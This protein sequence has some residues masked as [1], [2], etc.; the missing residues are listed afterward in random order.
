[1][2]RAVGILAQHDQ[3]ALKVDA[4][5]GLCRGH[6]KLNVVRLGGLGT[7]P[8]GFRMDGNFPVPEELEVKISD[9]FLE[10]DL[11]LFLQGF[12]LREER[13]SHAVGSR[14]GKIEPQ[15][16]DSVFQKCV[17][18]LHQD[19]CPIAARG[20]S[21]LTASVLHVLQHG[22]RIAD[23]GPGLRSVDVG[24]KSNAARIVFVGWVVKALV[25]VIV[26][27]HSSHSVASIRY[28]QAACE[29]TL[30]P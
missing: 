23:D 9:V 20:F 14:H 1:M 12:I 6:E 17:G 27:P 22:D 16:S 25:F 2:N 28:N 11:A 7:G 3:F 21:A 24:D 26:S 13:R 29:S 8:E 19:A 30:S 18:Y 10:L 15:R 4:V 5:E